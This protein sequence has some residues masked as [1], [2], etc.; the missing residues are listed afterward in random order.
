MMKTITSKL[1]E[2]AKDRTILYEN[3]CRTEVQKVDDSI[4]ADLTYTNAWSLIDIRY[5]VNAARCHYHFNDVVKHLKKHPI[6]FF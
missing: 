1:I 5:L 2:K 6:P 3:I 4:L